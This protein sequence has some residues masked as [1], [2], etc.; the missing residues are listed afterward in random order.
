MIWKEILTWLDS[1]SRQILDKWNLVN[2]NSRGMCIYPEHLK[3]QVMLYLGKAK[4]L[5]ANVYTAKRIFV[6]ESSPF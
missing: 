3:C 6:S 1:F 2:E 5:T 4:N